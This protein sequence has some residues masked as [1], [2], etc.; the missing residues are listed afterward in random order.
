V[1]VL[2][3]SGSLRAQSFNSA[4]LRAA[5]AHL[6]ADVVVTWETGLRDLPYFDQDLEDAGGHGAVHDFVARC[7][8]A[9]AVLVAAPEYNAGLP[10]VLKNALDW[11]SRP[12]GSSPLKGKAG[13]VIGT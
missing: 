5:V 10:G 9:D 1:H 2:A 11:A 12:P 7:E 13:A 6:P 4:L 3:I 8:R